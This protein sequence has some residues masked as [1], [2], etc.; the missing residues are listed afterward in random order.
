MSFLPVPIRFGVT[1]GGGPS[2]SALGGNSAMGPGSGWSGGLSSAFK[3]I[4]MGERIKDDR[5]S[6]DEEM[7]VQAQ[8]GGYMFGS[9]RKQP[10]CS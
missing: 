2:G 7:N 9:M 5:D 4:D 1:D 6:S 10:S 8:S 3:G